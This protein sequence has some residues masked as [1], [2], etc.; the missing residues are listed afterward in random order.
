MLNSAIGI[1]AKSGLAVCSPHSMA[2][3]IEQKHKIKGISELR[4]TFKTKD[5]QEKSL[6]LWKP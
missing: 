4:A 1:G 3:G 6:A 5:F 2:Q